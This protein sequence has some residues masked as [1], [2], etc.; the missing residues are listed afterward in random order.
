MR[1]P[2]LS[3]GDLERASYVKRYKR[4]FMDVRFA[5]D[6]VEAIHCA[7]TGSMRSCLAENAPV[8][9]KR[10]NNPARKLK[11]SLE[12]MELE[13]GMACLNTARANDFVAAIFKRYMAKS[14]DVC[15]EGRALWDA[16]F[17]F[18]NEL[19]R[20]PRYSKE[21]RFDFGFRSTHSCG[22][23]EVKSVSL[24]L[25][26]KCLAFPDAVT[27]RGQK[28]LAHLTQSVQNGETAYLFFVIM[29]GSRRSSK[30]VA[31]YFRAASEIDPVYSDALDKA[32]K[33][34]VRVRILVPEI[35]IKG[36]GM[37]GYFEYRND[38]SK[39]NTI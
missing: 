5:D 16:D 20:E 21:T 6:R 29:R 19:V 32:V 4:F 1:E 37:R 25:N 33:A 15:F 13:D 18:W 31:E 30:E 26:E 12:L 34:G 36:L 27:E 8:Y 9:L 28:H 17:S 3:F 24:R 22:W 35:D 7:N 14:L 2:I 10:N 11:A 23:L 39:R 38:E